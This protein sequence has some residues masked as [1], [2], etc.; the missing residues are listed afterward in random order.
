[1]VRRAERNQEFCVDRGRSRRARSRQAAARLRA[2]GRLQ[3]SRKRYQAPRERGEVWITERGCA[4]K[5]RLGKADLWRALS[6]DWPSSLLLQAL[7]ARHR[8][9][10]E[11][12]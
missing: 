7:R 12:S 5:Q 3:H 1:M 8:A 9:E 10:T 11:Q 2:L 4:W 6:A